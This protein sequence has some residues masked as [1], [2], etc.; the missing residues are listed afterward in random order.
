MKKPSSYPLYKG[1]SEKE[2]DEVMKQVRRAT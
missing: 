2:N 1:T